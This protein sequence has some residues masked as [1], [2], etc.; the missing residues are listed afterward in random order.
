MSLMANIEKSQKTTKDG[1]V[2]TDKSREKLQPEATPQEPKRLEPA[3]ITQDKESNLVDIRKAK[4][5]AKNS[6]QKLK[7]T[8]LDQD[9]FLDGEALKNGKKNLR[10][11]RYKIILA[12]LFLGVIIPSLLTSIY[13][14]FIAS[15]QFHSTASFAVR[16]A[17]GPAPTDI[18]G[19]VMQSGADTTVSNSYILNDYLESQSFFEELSNQFDLN[20]IYAN[21]DYDWFFRM[22][23]GKS[24]ERNLAYWQSRIDNKFDQLSGILVVE[25]ITFTPKEAQ[26]IMQFIVKKSEK[27]INDLSKTAHD[28][29]IASAQKTVA[30]AELRL[31]TVRSALLKYRE[32]TQEVS[33]EEDAKLT[34]KI[35]GEL[36]GMIV[37][38]EALL[39]TLVGYLDENSPRVRIASDEIEVLKKKLELERQRLGSGGVATE[40][41]TRLSNENLPQRILSYS[42]LYLEQEFAEQYYT[43]ALAGLEKARAEASNKEM[44]LATFINPTLSHEAQYPKRFTYIFTVFLVLLGIWSVSILSY[45]NMSDRN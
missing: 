36:H 21:T 17:S 3:S 20:Q 22:G 29:A 23:E 32:G 10:L 25:V 15:D 39:G 14:I 28:R 45:Y 24:L 12:S 18:L 43:T 9:K 31:K 7:K 2:V 33:P 41:N 13:M 37:E 44:Y 4:I 6:L 34:Y 1:A 30:S 16:S 42:D 40:Q 8:A 11:L 26:A 5:K 27:L 35:I 38:K 19:V